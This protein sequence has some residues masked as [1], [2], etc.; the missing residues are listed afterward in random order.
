MDAAPYNNYKNGLHI[1]YVMSGNSIIAKNIILQLSR[2]QNHIT[3]IEMIWF[4]NHQ[5]SLWS[6][7]R[8][9]ER[10]LTLKTALHS[11][12]TI[13]FESFYSFNKNEDLFCPQSTH[14]PIVVSIHRIDDYVFLT[15]IFKSSNLIPLWH[16]RRKSRATD[17]NINFF[18]KGQSK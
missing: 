4:P 5:N 12:Q 13:F 1:S 9:N 6:V 2:H 15:L 18:S 10:G 17:W 3:R 11:V 16:T 7:Y 8:G 14:Y